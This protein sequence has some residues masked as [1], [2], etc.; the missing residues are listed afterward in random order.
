MIDTR[1]ALRAFYVVVLGVALT[2]AGQA[3]TDW[4]GWWVPF[5]FAAVAAVELGGVVLS[6]HADARRQL[7]E[8]AL[9]ARL[10]SAAVATGAVAANWF[11]HKA[12]LGQAAFFAGMSALGYGVWLIDSAARR[13]DALR[14]A[15]KLPPTAPVFGAVRWLRHPWLTRRARQLALARPDLGLYGSVD[16]A[17]ADVRAE[18]RQAAISAALREKITATVN[19]T[20]ATIAVNTFDLDEIARR[21]AS[22]ADYDGLTAL[23]AADLTPATLTAAPAV[24]M[25]GSRPPDDGQDD[26]I[27]A[28]TVPVTAALEAAP[29]TAPADGHTDGQIDGLSDAEMTATEPANVAPES[30]SNDGPDDGH[31]SVTAPVKRAPRRKPTGTPKAGTRVHR[32]AAKMPGAPAAQIAKKAGVSESTARRHLAALNG[33]NTSKEN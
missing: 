26:V 24:E 18:R 33:H 17:K 13:R 28:V 31:T 10:L 11:G 12:Q 15:G 20:M 2:G 4:L 14:R 8:R 30:P 29:E 3:A 21:L 7:G 16:A 32:A 1:S 19:P 25:V 6:M 5:A 9:A 23:L 22:N 27:E